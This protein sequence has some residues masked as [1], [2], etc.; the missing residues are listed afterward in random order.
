[1]QQQ[2][3]RMRCA[4]NT[5]A[6]V[7]TMGYLHDGHLSLIRK[8]RSLADTLVVSIFVNP[9]QFGPGEDF[10]SYPRNF[11]RDSSLVK[12]ENADILFY[13]KAEELYPQG[14]QTRVQ[15]DIL[16]HYLC[17]LS[18]PV[19]FQGVTTVVTKL[20]H[21]V[22][23][24][25]AIFGQK[26]YQQLLIVRRMVADLNMDIRI[27]GCP[28]VR[29]PDGL[30]MSSRNAY[31]SPQ[32]RPAACALF[33]AM[34]ETKTLLAEGL[35]LSAQLIEAA[36]KRITA[37]S[38]AAIDYIAICDP[39]TLLDLEIIDRPALMALAVRI[40]KTRLIDNTMLHP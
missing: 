5:I 26:D 13:P 16:P 4:G 11:E 28:T 29:E 39:Y 7:P 40:G 22:K 19:F 24:H 2:A 9:T 20:F 8:G 12:K 21:I 30:A 6:F 38:N 36:S 14:F 18:R 25:V 3:E 27:I 17:G 10:Q 23:P 1:M 37:Y 15:L 32:Q 35:N 34:N 33:Q 31:L